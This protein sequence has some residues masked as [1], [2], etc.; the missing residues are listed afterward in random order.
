MDAYGLA[1]NTEL[2]ADVCIIGGGP[3]GLTIARELAGGDLRICLLESGGLEFEQEADDLS[4]GLAVSEHRPRNALATGRRR[5]LGGTSNIWLYDTQPG[6]VIKAARMLAPRAI[7]LER[8][9]GLPW[10]GW[11]F[12]IRTL[13][14]FFRRAERVF[15]IGP[16]DRDVAGSTLFPG[17]QPLPLNQR[18]LISTVCQYGNFSRSIREEVLAE[19]QVSVVLHA[20][21]QRLENGGPDG[22][23]ESA[24]V[25]QV[26]V[27]RARSSLGTPF[28]VRARAFV[29]AAGGIE[30]PRLLL[31][32]DD[33]RRGGIGNEHDLV[34][35]FLLEHPEF[36]L[37]VIRPA[38]GLLQRAAL[39]D[40]RWVNGVLLSGMVA[41]ADAVLRE[42][43]LLNLGALLVPQPEA[44]GGEA[45]QALK[46]L[47]TLRRGGDWVSALED[48][49]W[50][51]RH[52]R[53][54]VEAIRCAT[55]LGPR[56]F[57]ES[58]GGWSAAPMGDPRLAL[59]EVVAATE[60]A[61]NPDNR[62][63]LQHQR[64]RLGQRLPRVRWRWGEDE[65][66]SIHQAREIFREEVA[67]AGIG[68]FIPWVALEDPAP[69]LL[70]P[71]SRARDLLGGFHH[72]MGTT[73]M[74]VDPCQG[75]VDAD[76]RVHGTANVYVAGSSV[77]PTAVG[78]ANPTFT[79]VALALRLSDH[80]KGEYTR[81]P[82]RVHHP[83][84]DVLAVSA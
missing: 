73:R 82:A 45:A 15:R 7:D 60:Q 37:G 62:V 84:G 58:H 59:L 21:A 49:R 78:Y 76:C 61:P 26:Q 16:F 32:S 68:E 81:A 80:L 18:R 83:R 20:V 36:R 11:P 39:Y 40:L 41:L 3:A 54:T 44:Y 27:V 24:D 55:L 74:H 10:S 38:P 8:R 69:T 9:P 56:L 13:Q 51:G 47:A 50:L 28:S 79:V 12:T 4:R 52:P 6:E 46:R 1:A 77:F 67:A 35:R 33:Q 64:D 70:A 53:E 65:Q 30:N 19:E 31:C 42:H 25:Q 14:P 22:Q 29:L 75:V 23:R 71:I 43:E 66:R 48:A 34:G 63:T 5:Q 72:P 2:Q 57:R 17:E